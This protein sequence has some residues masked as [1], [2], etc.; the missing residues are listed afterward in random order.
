MSNYQVLINKLD[1][2]IRKY[3]ANQLL[4]GVLI[5]VGAIIVIILVLIFGEYFLYF[6]A[7]FKISAL[8]ILS[9]IIIVASIM[10][11][12]KPLLSM[13]KLGKTLNYESAAQIIGDHF[14]EIQDKL[15]NVLQLNNTDQAG[16]STALIT[17]SIEQKAAT[18]SLFPFKAAINQKDT[19][20]FIP[21]ALVALMIL[22]VSYFVAPFIFKNAGMRWQQANISFSPPAP[23]DFLLE[24]KNLQ[25]KKNQPITINL[26][27]K[28]KKIPQ[29]IDLIADNVKLPMVKKDNLTYTY[30]FENVD[31]A[32]DF[33]FEGG[34]YSSQNHQINLQI[35]PELLSTHII[36]KYPAYLNKKEEV[37]DNISDLTLPEG[38]IVTW[39]F[40]TKNVDKVAL[41]FP[42]QTI[43]FQKN[44]DLFE[45]N[46]S[47]KGNTSFQIQ[48]H[49]NQQNESLLMPTNINIIKDQFPQ[50]NVNVIKDPKSENQILIDGIAAD[51]YGITQ[52]VAVFEVKNK[53]GKILQ[54]TKKELSNKQSQI[55]DFQH[56]FDA[57][58][59]NIPTEG[60]LQYYIIAWDNDGINGS[61]SIKS[62]IY[63]IDPLGGKKVNEFI[64]ELNND[65][66]NTLSSS[67]KQAKQT[68]QLT[69]NTQ[70]NLLNNPQFNSQSERQ[71]EQLI[72]E[73]EA[74]KAQLESL[75]KKLKQ[76]Q[77]LAAEK[78]A[79]PE[80]K[81]QQ[82]AVEK[83]LN[84]LLNKD[85]QNQLD[86]LNK[87]LAEKNKDKAFDE[88]QKMQQENKL[89]NM[90]MEKLN[91][92][93]QQLTM[94]MGL[95]DLAKKVKDLANK[96][97]ML[98]Q[99]TDKQSTDN[100]SL[101]KEQVDIQEALDKMMKDAM[102]ELEP[103]NKDL[104][105]PNNLDKL[106]TEAKDAEKE[107]N[108]S[109]QELTKNNKNKA[110]DSQKKAAEKL[111]QL[112]KQ[113]MA[114]S[115][116]ME[117]EQVDIDIKMTRQLLT[118]LLRISFEQEQLIKDVSMGGSGNLRL[119]LLT[120]QQGNLRNQ[121]KIVRDSLFVL[122][123]RIAKLAPNINKETYELTSQMDKSVANLEQRSL[124]TAVVS[125]Q[126]AMTS[127]NNLALLLNDLLS[128][129]MNSQASGSSGSGEGK[130]KPG[131]GSGSG[132][133]K[134][135]IT[136]QQ[137]LG[138]GMQSGQQ[139]GKSGKP[140]Q[141]GESGEGE[142][143][144]E[145]KGGKDG[146]GGSE[147]KEGQDG[148]GGSNGSGS[149]GSGSGGDNKNNSK[150]Q[151]QK[152]GELAQQQA[153][154]RKQ[155]E[156]LNAQLQ[157]EGI[158]KDVQKMLNDI[159]KQMDLNETDLVFRNQLDKIYQRNQLI[160]TRMLAAEKAIQEQEF[161]DKRA[162]T[163]GKEL[164]RPIP[165]SLQKIVDEKQSSKEYYKFSNP[166]LKPF[167][168]KIADEYYKNLP[169]NP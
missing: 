136:K 24:N 114:M 12:I 110:S 15:L 95:E 102:K 8:T 10:L 139:P 26:K 96:E 162:A 127:T 89:M 82:E 86:K 84:E 60:S 6:P 100:Q 33:H 65:M 150:E 135:I 99:K 47:F 49:N 27:L 52:V 91:A 164:P 22:L 30:T 62:P 88:L 144:K 128:H 13:Y 165:A 140:G 64:K 120:K 153:I 2:F 4:K 167:Y 57:N 54:T 44:K 154:L 122:S 39:K 125:Q 159:A 138:K 147:G 78:N 93:I 169:K 79:S 68:D 83:Q 137:Q 43:N 70:Q 61:K 20:R 92:L 51:D 1:Q 75:D 19:K 115:N 107:M 117:P 142:S 40:N 131:Q 146:K 141:D 112:S 98:N 85:L 42:Q 37:M 34:G 152:L 101:A 134:D 32:I 113:M 116:G 158:P 50:L 97:T 71:V 72:T 36:V 38:T 118:N 123:K 166:V 163:S 149:G 25:V 148:Q 53:D 106:K 23:F 45:N 69:K 104:N 160:L 156:D 129:L 41:L 126:Y 63:T 143:G 130:P 48:L 9:G 103:I 14:S 58:E 73:K 151:A 145:G 28:G 59:Y 5:F 77:K 76:Q 7:W 16:I 124:N 67:Q 132:K 109:K 105:Q 133:M 87:L 161:D 18:I 46:I 35:L 121:T 31:K 155:L 3:Y 94:Q 74:L 21:F 157:K 80:L 108:D 90:D 81:K 111:N 168:Q 17:A 119:P 56:Y 29:T 66:M 55:V 11:I